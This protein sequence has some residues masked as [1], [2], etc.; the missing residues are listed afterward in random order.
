MLT[1]QQRGDPAEDHTYVNSGDVQTMSG[2]RR[3][4]CCTHPVLVGVLLCVALLVGIAGGYLAAYYLNGLDHLDS[5]GKGLKPT[6]V[7]STGIKSIFV[8]TSLL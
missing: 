6:Y 3:R 8:F 1:N 5:S 7:Y 2:K 4:R